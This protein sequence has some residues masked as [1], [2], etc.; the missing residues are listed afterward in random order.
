MK[1]K[2][3]KK[4]EADERNL[5]Y[6][7]KSMAEKMLAILKRPGNSAREVARLTAPNPPKQ[8]N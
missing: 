2:E 6:Q 1:S 7:N 5:F 3:Q 8:E 4:K